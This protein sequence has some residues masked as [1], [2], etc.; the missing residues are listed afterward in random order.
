LLSSTWLTLGAQH[1]KASKF[2]FR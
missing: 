1:A 2:I